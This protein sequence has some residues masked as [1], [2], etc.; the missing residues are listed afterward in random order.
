MNKTEGE[1]KIKIAALKYPG[2]KSLAIYDIK[3]EQFKCSEFRYS[4]GIGK[5]LAETMTDTI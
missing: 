2:G 3:L 4:F 1:K 5:K